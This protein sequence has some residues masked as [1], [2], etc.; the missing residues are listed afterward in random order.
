M[1]NGGSRGRA[2]RTVLEQKIWERGETLA[3]FVEYAERFA[4]QVGE[5][6]TLSERNLKRLMAG[7]AADGSPGGTPRVATSRLLER[8]FGTS[9]QELLS[10]PGA[11]S[12][13]LYAEGEQELRRML[14]VARRVDTSILALIHS[15]LDAIRRID[16]QLGAPVVREEV[17]AKIRQVNIL[18]SFSL[19][20]GTRDQLAAIRAE[21]GT[22]AG[23]QALD[24]GNLLGSWRQ[25]ESAK[26]AINE[27]SHF[28]FKAHTAAEQAFVLVDLGNADAADELLSTTRTVAEKNAGHLLRAWLAAAHGEVL[29]ARGNRSASLRA[30]DRA[31]RLM[32]T[33]TAAASGP[34]VML[35]EIHLAR[36]RG[37]ALSRV[38]DPEAAGVLRKALSGLDQ[39][40]TRAEASLR[41]DLAAAL[42]VQNERE[43]A[44]Q[45]VTKA[46]AL[47]QDIGSVR[48]NRRISRLDEQIKR[49]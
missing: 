19:T 17:E 35:D 14:S 21:L 28:E 43:S 1:T 7:R 23:W 5:R 25:Y 4:H 2:P 6:G 18:L 38:G 39:S 36:W 46:R 41:V 42:V 11:T 29:A 24:L 10:P 40:F 26:A 31:I 15:Q 12:D 30:F 37:H 22:L 47:A 8:L 27:T 34:Y 33:D 32:P 45:Q 3:E 20:P 48:Q 44:E 9:I 49:P 16:R 13:A